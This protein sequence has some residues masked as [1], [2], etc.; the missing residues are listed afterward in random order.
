MFELF[1]I[2]VGNDN[3]VL[4]LFDEQTKMP[5][6]YPLMYSIDRLNLRSVSTQE[7]TLRAIKFFYNFWH[8]K[9]DSTF[10]YSF[11][12]SNHDPSIAINELDDFFHY[13]NGGHIY[14]PNLISLEHS[15]VSNI[16]TN[17]ERVRAFARFIKYISI[18]YVNSYHYKE[19]PKE[20]LRHQN[21]LLVSLKSNTD[22]YKKISKSRI[23][24]EVNSHQGFDS[25]TDEMVNMLYK[26]IMPSSSKKINPLNPFRILENQIRN[27]VIVLILLNYGLRVSELML[28][29]NSSIKTSKDGSSFYLIITTMSDNSKDNRYRKPSIKTKDSIRSIAIDKT[30]YQCLLQYISKVRPNSKENNQLIFTTLRQPYKPLSYDAIYLI[31]KKIDEALTTHFPQFTDSQYLGC[32]KKITPHTARHTWAYSMLKNTYNKKYNE[33]IRLSGRSNIDFTN[34]GIMEDAKDELRMLAGWHANSIMPDLYAKRFISENANKEN[35]RRIHTLNNT[36]ES[37]F[38][39]EDTSNDY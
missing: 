32:M 15:S 12:Q 29:E 13:L 9:F 27:F 23:T 18:K 24:T 19:S 33:I 10:C 4:I 5:L 30:D 16:F 28:L 31:F 35:L 3:N 1:R 17:A 34:N 21:R 8:Q 6:F 25:L 22:N 26:I 7:S 39:F 38:Y 36:I 11:N 14:S 20:I 2:A 37:D